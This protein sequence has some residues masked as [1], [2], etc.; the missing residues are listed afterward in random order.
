MSQMSKQ[1]AD[2]PA[3]EADKPPSRNRLVDFCEVLATIPV[4]S[5]SLQE[6]DFCLPSA[7]RL[8]TLLRIVPPTSVDYL[9][10]DGLNCL[11]RLCRNAMQILKWRGYEGPH[12]PRPEEVLTFAEWR[13]LLPLERPLQPVLIMPE[14]VQ[15]PDLLEAWIERYPKQEQCLRACMDAKEHA[16]L[17]VHFGGG[18][19]A[20]R[21]ASSRQRELKVVYRLILTWQ[22]RGI[23]SVLIAAILEPVLYCFSPPGFTV[24]VGS[25]C[26]YGLNGWDDMFIVASSTESE[27]L[28]NYESEGATLF[29]VAVKRSRNFG[30]PHWYGK[31]DAPVPGLSAE[32]A[33]DMV[34]NHGTTPGLA[35]DAEEWGHLPLEYVISCLHNLHE[36]GIA[37]IQ[38]NYDWFQL[39]VKQVTVGMGD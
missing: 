18:G 30:K 20:Q 38:G 28:S 27:E 2:G 37:P 25:F 34:I 13:R 32:Y 12:S 39:F 26:R 6:F 8:Y 23:P 9:S 21:S 29:H 11:S 19:P 17:R 24:L 10:C 33:R 3:L 16:L 15:S 1:Q 4:A 36:M 22:R 31:A 7:S 14:E 35:P 5:S